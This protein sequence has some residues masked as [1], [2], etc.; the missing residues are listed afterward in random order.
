MDENER[1]RVWEQFKR[2]WNNR[3]SPDMDLD[4][5]CELFY[6]SDISR[7]AVDLIGT[8]TH[9]R[10]TIEGAIDVPYKL[11]PRIFKYIHESGRFR[12]WISVRGEDDID[13]II[14]NGLDEI[15]PVSKRVDFLDIIVSKCEEYFG[16]KWIRN[17]VLRWW[18]EIDFLEEEKEKILERLAYEYVLNWNFVQ[19]LGPDAVETVQRLICRGSIRASKIDGFAFVDLQSIRG[20]QPADWLSPRIGSLLQPVTLPLDIRD[21]CLQM[22]ELR[23]VFAGAV[24]QNKVLDRDSF[25]QALRRLERDRDPEE[26]FTFF[27][28]YLDFSQYFPGF[29]NE[30]PALRFPL[31]QFLHMCLLLEAPSLNAALKKSEL[32]LLP[33]AVMHIL[34]RDAVTYVPELRILRETD[35]RWRAHWVET[36]GEALSVIFLEKALNLDITSLSR[37]PEQSGKPTPDFRAQTYSDEPIVFE[38]KGS[39]SMN[40]HKKQRQDALVQLGKLTKGMGKTKRNIPWSGEGRAF[41]ISLFTA[42]QGDKDFSLLHADDPAFDFGEFFSEDWLE[43]ARRIHYTAVLETAQLFGTADALLHKRVKDMEHEPM[44]KFT[45]EGKAEMSEHKKGEVPS[46]FVGNFLNVQDIARRLRHPKLRSIEKLRIFA[47]LD[48]WVFDELRRDRLPSGKWP[49]E[50]RQEMDSKRSPVVPGW[51]L[52]PGHKPDGPPRGV[53][54]SLADGAFLAVE[55]E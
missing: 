54:S 9:A 25:R 34:G 5:F 27:S 24:M 30:S 55:L 45:I 31:I 42:I 13:D 1:K 38:S 3:E 16:R 26:L 50:S 4:T 48:A 49:K 7:E 18:R 20:S 43:E 41:A 22:D 11:L 12:V 6:I 32:H 39:T 51:G 35:R 14:I 19:Q 8:S 2:S 40:T 23:R 21:S 53:Y 33:E 36:A 17:R 15:V 46:V 44:H 29:S 10:Q 52:L 37:I 28:Q 47:G